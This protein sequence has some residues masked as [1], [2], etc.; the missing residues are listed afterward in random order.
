MH[1][2]WFWGPK[3]QESLGWAVLAW[4]PV[5]LQ[6][7]SRGWSSGG[8]GHGAGRADHLRVTGALPVAFP[9]VALPYSKAASGQL[10]RRLHLAW[11]CRR[12]CSPRKSWKT[13]LFSGSGVTEVNPAILR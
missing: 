11:G 13:M 12:G 8:L 5:L 4:G 3:T 9:P 2:Q 10:L 1:L 6:S 7:D